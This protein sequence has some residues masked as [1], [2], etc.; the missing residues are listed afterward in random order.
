MIV[1]YSVVVG[2]TAARL[3]PEIIMIMGI[4]NGI[5][6]GVAMALGDFI[7]SKSEAEFVRL[8]REREQ[9]EVNN[10]QECEEEEMRQIYMEK[11]MSEQDAREVVQIL[12]RNKEAWIN[13]MLVEELGLVTD[14]SNPVFNAIVTFIA[15]C[16]FGSG[17]FI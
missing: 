6:D 14:E 7:S 11:G 3:E 8:E 2:A 12:A 5:A 10:I 17:T 16:A 13:I 1:G 15:F 4:S 9:W